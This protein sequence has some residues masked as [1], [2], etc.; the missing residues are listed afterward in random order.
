M[1]KKRKMEKTVT[2]YQGLPLLFIQEGGGVHCTKR[3]VV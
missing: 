3:I 2:K 1:E